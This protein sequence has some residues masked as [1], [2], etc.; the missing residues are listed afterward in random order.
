MTKRKALS[1]SFPISHSLRCCRTLVSGSTSF[2]TTN[3][4][5]NTAEFVAADKA[6]GDDLSTCRFLGS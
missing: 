6:V 3:N 1:N 4:G 5:G 2:V